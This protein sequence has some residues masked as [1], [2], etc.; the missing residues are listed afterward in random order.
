MIR[1]KIFIFVLYKFFNCFFLKY[2]PFSWIILWK[3]FTID[4]W[5]FELECQWVFL[6]CINDS[7]R[8]T[9]HNDYYDGNNKTFEWSFFICEESIL[10]DNI[11]WFGCRLNLNLL[12]KQVLILSKSWVKWDNVIIL[13]SSII[14]F[15]CFKGSKD[16]YRL[17]LIIK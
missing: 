6:S 14:S 13:K 12:T 1:C 11:S 7:E 17:L 3:F 4:F 9:K 2:V 8:D 5:I 15:F 10:P 16:W